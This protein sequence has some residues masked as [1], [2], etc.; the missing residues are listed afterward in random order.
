MLLLRLLVEFTLIFAADRLTALFSLRMIL[1][2]LLCSIGL[3][4][5]V[6]PLDCMI[7]TV[8]SLPAWCGILRSFV[9]SL[10]GGKET[11][12]SEGIE[13]SWRATGGEERR[14]QWRWHVANVC[15]CYGMI[16]PCSQGDS[17]VN[18]EVH[19]EFCTIMTSCQLASDD[20]DEDDAARIYSRARAT[21]IRGNQKS[22]MKNLQFQMNRCSIHE[23]ID[24]DIEV[25]D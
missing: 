5:M 13:T 9:L 21:I 18:L 4:I 3:G 19:K 6:V 15:R 24:R 14:R 12:R 22:K 25:N 20:D 8:P 2:A 11:C 7:I 16:C 23:S 1:H 17:K 10:S